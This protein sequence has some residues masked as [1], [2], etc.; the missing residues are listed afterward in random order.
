[1]TLPVIMTASGPVPNSPAALNS[2]L[3]ATVEAE[4]AG[5][6]ANL[7]GLL[8]EDLTSTGTAMLAQMDQARVD[9]IDSVTPY[10]ANAFI[11]AQQGVMLG[12][13]QGQPTN[14]SVLVVFTD[15][16]APGYVLPQGFIVGD[17]TYQYVLQDGGVLASNGVS[18]PLLAVANQSGTWAV[19]EG[20]VTQIVTSLPT[21]YNETMTVTNPQAGTPSTSTETVPSYRSRIIVANQV[22]GQGT[23]DYIQSLLMDVPGVIPRLVS[24]LQ[25]TFGWE[26]L[27]GGGD[28]YQVAGAIYLGVLDLST[29][30]GSNTTARNVTATITSSPNQYNVTYVNPPQQVVT[31][32]VIWNTNLSNFT[33]GA[34]VN[35]LGAP[36][37]QSY[38]N[39]IVVGQPM[40]LNAMSAAFQAAIAS[41]L[42]VANLSAFTVTV[43][44]N[45]SVVTPEAGTGII[46]GDPES[47]FQ[48]SNTAVT[49][50]QG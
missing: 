21:P 48:A 11:L 30:V 15:T 14:T 46:L 38:V 20:S 5:F 45:G 23:P 43:T 26:V 2:D 33:A 34:Q 16:S 35:Q 28:P 41:V 32:S 42:P 3:I 6:T 19:P 9:A 1:M 37:I 13:P 8:L 47:Y 22:A 40:N 44:I 36:A 50:T 4:D 12:I 24:I 18:A 25:S 27:C 49:V 7:P 10:G 17:G 39:S 31:V 29:I